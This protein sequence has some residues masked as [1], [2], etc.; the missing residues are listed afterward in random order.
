MFKLVSESLTKTRTSTA[1]H[2]WITRLLKEHG[3]G[4]IASSAC[5]GG[6]YAGNYWENRD[7]SPEAVL[8]A[9]RETTSKNG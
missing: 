1:I 3:E 8:N 2:E 6:V 5:L 4:I 9:M 7:E